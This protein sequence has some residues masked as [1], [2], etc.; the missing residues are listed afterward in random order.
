[1]EFKLSKNW[2]SCPS[3]TL[4][5]SAPS[6]VHQYQFDQHTSYNVSEQPPQTSYRQFR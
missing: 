1:M 3:M 6:K 5:N 2:T 4:T